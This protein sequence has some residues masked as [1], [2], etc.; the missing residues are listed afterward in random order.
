[1]LKQQALN[2]SEAESVSLVLLYIET[3]I[4][5]TGVLSIL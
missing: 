5:C 4:C 2:G 3:T 1:M